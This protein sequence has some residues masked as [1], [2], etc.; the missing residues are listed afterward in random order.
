MTCQV[1]IKCLEK[2]VLSGLKHNQDLEI[3]KLPFN[4]HYSAGEPIPYKLYD[5]TTRNAHE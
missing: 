4:N 3:I 1:A 2:I 5:I